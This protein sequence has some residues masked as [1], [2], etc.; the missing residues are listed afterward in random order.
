[1]LDVLNNLQI[2]KCLPILLYALEVCNLGK[3]VLQSLDFTVNRFFMKLFRTSNIETVLYDQ[4][5]FGCELPSVLLVK[6]YDKFTEKLA[7]TFM[8]NKGEYIK[9]RGHL[10]VW[11]SW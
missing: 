7:R 2:Q 11:R 3:R 8:V 10:T 5:V 9:L 1:M 4:T 6:R